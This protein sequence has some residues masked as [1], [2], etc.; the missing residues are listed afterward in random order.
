MGHQKVVLTGAAPMQIGMTSVGRQNSR[1]SIGEVG[2]PNCARAH[3]L[4]K[5][6]LQDADIEMTALMTKIMTSLGGLPGQ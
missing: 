1:F 2:N 5:A 4:L 6:V 3:S